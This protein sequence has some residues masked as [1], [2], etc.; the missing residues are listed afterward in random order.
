[1]G[2][3]IIATADVFVQSATIGETACQNNCTES[4]FLA[5]GRTRRSA[6]Q[7][8]SPHAAHVFPY[9]TN[10]VAHIWPEPSE[11]SL[12]HSVAGDGVVAL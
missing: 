8:S 3:V 10:S 5:G 1:M 9:P 6:T 11:K 4:S 7:K 12:G 2:G